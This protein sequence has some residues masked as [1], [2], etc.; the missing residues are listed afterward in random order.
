[1]ASWLRPR[2]AE[3]GAALASQYLN[4]DPA[5]WCTVRTGCR[6]SS[7]LTPGGDDSDAQRLCCLSSELSE[8][9]KA[10]LLQL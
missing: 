5:G 4:Q 7:S 3:G 1:M 8:G 2:T 10:G 9:T 6:R